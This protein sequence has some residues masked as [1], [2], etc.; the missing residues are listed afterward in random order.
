MLDKLECAGRRVVALAEQHTQNQSSMPDDRSK[1]DSAC[2][3]IGWGSTQVLLARCGEPKEES[4]LTCTVVPI[5]DQTEEFVGTGVGWV[6]LA[7]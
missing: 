6:R 1:V 7:T 5:V 4:T 3:S 2:R